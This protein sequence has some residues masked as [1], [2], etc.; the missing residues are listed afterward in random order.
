MPTAKFTIEHSVAPQVA[1]PSC[2]MLYMFVQPR[3]LERQVLLDTCSEQCTF[4]R[5]IY[6]SSHTFSTENFL[7]VIKD[8]LHTLTSY[9]YTLEGYPLFVKA[10]IWMHTDLHL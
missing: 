5:D 2:M 4:R 9:R 7:A 3:S 10:Q 1:Q 6:A 8:I